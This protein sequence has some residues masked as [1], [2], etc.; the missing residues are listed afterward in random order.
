MNELMC[1][2]GTNVD[3][4]TENGE[5]LFEIYSTGMALG[6]C[7]RNAIG[8]AYPRKDRIEE[9]LKSAE[10]QPCVRNGHKYITESQLYDLMLEMKTDKV[11]PFRKWVTS[12]VLPTVRKTGGYVSNSEQFVANYFSG[13]DS[14]QKALLTAMLDASKQQSEKIRELAPKA[15]YC[16]KILMSPDVITPTQLAKMFGMSAQKFHKTCNDLGIMYKVNKQWVLY[17]KH[18]NKGYTKTRTYCDPAGHAHQT[19]CFSAKGI[20]FITG[21]FEKAG[22]SA[23]KEE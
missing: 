20:Q 16:D 7:R 4:I 14:Q 12:T 23:N 21:E 15:E 6:Q 22:Y 8:S 13:V 17:Q 2:E 3:I 1:F 18:Q 9:N 11:K 5:P 19:T 10:I